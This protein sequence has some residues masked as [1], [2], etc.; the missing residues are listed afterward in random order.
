MQIVCKPTGL[1]GSR[2]NHR[3]NRNSVRLFAQ[4]CVL[5][6]LLFSNRHK[7][8]QVAEQYGTKDELVEN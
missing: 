6:S 2:H 4:I 7:G 8:Q 3:D 1:E 5:V